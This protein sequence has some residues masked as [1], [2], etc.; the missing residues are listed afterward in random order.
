MEEAGKREEKLIAQAKIK[1][2]G[3]HRIEFE[4]LYGLYTGE[5]SDVQKAQGTGNLDQY[6]IE[7]QAREQQLNKESQ[8]EEG[9]YVAGDGDDI[10]DYDPY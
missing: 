1:I 8:L 3:R 6:Q 5:E 4:K 10:D 9:G 2:N 7:D